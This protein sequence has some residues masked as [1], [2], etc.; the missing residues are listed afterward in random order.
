M[1]DESILQRL[2]EGVTPSGDL[3]TRLREQIQCRIEPMALRAT[4]TGVVP[5][6]SLSTTLKQR[7]LFALRGSSVTS[8]LSDLVRATDLAPSRFVALRETILARLSPDPEGSLLHGSLKWAAAFAVFVLLIRAM[9]LV[10]LA[11]TTKADVGVQ[12]IPTGDDASIYVGGVWRSVVQPEIIRGPLMVRTGS[13]RVTVILNDDG[14]VR[15]EPN[16]TFKL[17]D[18]ADRPQSAAGP[19]A[20]LVRGQMWVL[21]LLPALTEGL[22]IETIQGEVTV[23]SGSASLSED[24]HTMTVSVY[25][26]GVTFH[27]GNQASFVV[28][29]EKGSAHGTAP[30]SIVTFPTRV[31][32]ASY[33]SENLQQDAVHRA[34]IAKLQQER[35]ERM[36]GILPTSI[37]YSAKRLSEEVDVLFTLTHDGRSEKRIQQADTR[38][39]EALALFKEGQNAQ[40]AVPLTEY[41][42]SLIAMASGT[43]DNLVK[44]LI[45]QQ[46]ADASASLT[47]M[48]SSGKIQL[49]GSAVMDV[50]A[51]IP[52]TKLNTKDIE[53]YVLVDKLTEINRTLAFEH[54][55]TGALMAYADVSPYLKSL[56]S[57]EK[58][59]PHPLLRK[60]AKSLLV[61]MSSLVKKSANGNQDKVLVAVQSDLHQY[62]PAESEAV[63]VSEEE[64]NEA[65]QKMVDRIFIFKAPLSRYN[66]L[67]LEMDNLHGNVN[68]GTLLRRLFRAVPENGLGGY[69]LTEIKNF[70]DELKGR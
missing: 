69:V 42:N 58:N 7:I 57:D 66:Q 50:G 59:G 56:L 44:F 34:E 14:V 54:N 31:F 39:S 15:L 51:A 38:L 22:S 27:A 25:D 62:L 13:S 48:T 45:R 11:P 12:L 8:E 1:L 3:R 55:L 37:F 24:G 64:L 61:T 28:S 35:R 41:R 49:V 5:P 17:H 53:G 52:D 36:A 6:P 9:P 26:R 16:T 30:F 65:V 60:E 23:N 70:G 21:G 32:T 18:I 46:V 2:A 4:V 19:T 40:A 29:G 10:F 68:R 63:L 43:G 33:V 20:T 47:P 67:M